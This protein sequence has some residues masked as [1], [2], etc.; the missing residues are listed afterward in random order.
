MVRIDTLGRGD[1]FV[2]VQGKR[3]TFERR[4]H[5]HSGAIIVR[6]DDGRED[7]FGACAMVTPEGKNDEQNER[8][9]RGD[10]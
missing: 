8:N 1:R 2:C 4:H 6:R 3:W 10:G 7:C 9:A 5:A